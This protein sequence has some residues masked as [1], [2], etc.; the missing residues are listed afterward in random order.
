MV[1][2]VSACVAPQPHYDLSKAVGS[3]LIGFDIEGA[4]TYATPDRD[5][6]FWVVMTILVTSNGV[7]SPVTSV[8]TPTDLRLAIPGASGTV[9]QE[10]C[11]LFKD[12]PTLLSRN[13]S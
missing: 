10:S 12:P 8:A 1:S 3:C 2:F 11:K 4:T 6:P 7:T 13:Q 5:G 9:A